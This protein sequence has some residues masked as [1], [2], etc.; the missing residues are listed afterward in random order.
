M[1][2]Y[3]YLEDIDNLKRLKQV[4][5]LD[6]DLGDYIDTSL[7]DAS[8]YPSTFEKE[9]Y[10]DRD[11]IF[12]HFGNDRS[13]I[14]R[15]AVEVFQLPGQDLDPFLH[16]YESAYARNTS[17]ELVDEQAYTTRINQILRFAERQIPGEL[18]LGIEN[19]LELA[20][21]FMEGLGEEKLTEYVN[22]GDSVS[23]SIL[24]G[25]SM[26]GDARKSLGAELYQDPKQTEKAL[27]VLESFMH[28][29]K[30]ERFGGGDFA[31]SNPTRKMEL[32][33]EPPAPD[34]M[35]SPL[36][37]AVSRPTLKSHVIMIYGGK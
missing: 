23:A 30:Y 4:K 3:P 27:Q 16:M 1:K 35:L 18:S 37:D 6:F 25:E 20:C 36:V 2:N 9:L 29:A 21:D 12:R 14:K 5:Y 22:E 7:F 31:F 34:E 19:L 32:Y 10:N 33:N 28:I 17:G 15:G 11:D 26:I 24:M 8:N 13:L